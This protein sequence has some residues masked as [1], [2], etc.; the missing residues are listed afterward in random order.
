M[1]MTRRLMTDRP[2]GLMAAPRQY[3][4]R[5]GLV[6]WI[7]DWQS[8]EGDDTGS[9]QRS[10]TKSGGAEVS[11]AHGDHS[12]LWTVP[13]I[14]AELP[15]FILDNRL[16]ECLAQIARCDRYVPGLWP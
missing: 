2:A 11:R 13:T 15:F 9:N 14:A 5:S 4:V 10:L 7:S 12:A 8:K 3:I 6:W 16:L 1:N